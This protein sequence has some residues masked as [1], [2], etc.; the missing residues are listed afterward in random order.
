MGGSY[1]PRLLC[2][3]LL[4]FNNCICNGLHRCHNYK[5][6]LCCLL[7]L[8]LSDMYR[9]V[10]LFKA[11]SAVVD[12]GESPSLHLFLDQTEAQR[13]EEKKAFKT[14]PPPPSYLRVWMTPFPLPHAP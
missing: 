9:C 14:A 6:T 3:S 1:V 12:L 11:M 2:M 13:T 7:P 4:V 5:Q 10:S 8:C